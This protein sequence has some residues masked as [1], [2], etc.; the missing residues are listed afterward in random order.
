MLPSENGVLTVDKETAKA[1]ETITITAKANEGYRV[2]KVFVNGEALQGKDGVY[3]FTM[4]DHGD[5]EVSA[6]FVSTQSGAPKTGDQSQTAIWAA[7]LV[8][9]G[10]AAFLTMKRRTNA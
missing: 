6:E 2:S 3:T 10:G 5:V 7:L 4:P 8:L 9:A 1:G